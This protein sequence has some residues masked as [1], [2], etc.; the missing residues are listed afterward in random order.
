MEL[1]EHTW[2]AHSTGAILVETGPGSTVQNLIAGIKNF[3][4]QVDDI[5]DVFLTHIHL[6]HAGAAGW[7]AQ[8]GCQ[9]HVHENGAAHLINPERLLAVL[10]VYTVIRWTTFW[11]NFYR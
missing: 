7:L 6:D 3:G 1:L 5:S 4:Y 9:I 2:F 8:Q 11:V 10:G